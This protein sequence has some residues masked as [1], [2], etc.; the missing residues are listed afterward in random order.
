[1]LRRGRARGLP[2]AL[3]GLRSTPFAGRSR[4]FTSSNSTSPLIGSTVPATL[5]S[6]EASRSGLPVATSREGTS[7]DGGRANLLGA[8]KLL[9]L[10]L[11]LSLGLRVAV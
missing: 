7:L 9:L 2:L 1:M 4:G 11:L 10:D 5:R 6:R 3:L 8:G